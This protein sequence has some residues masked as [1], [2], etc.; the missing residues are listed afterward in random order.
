MMSAH[1]HAEFFHAVAEGEA[2]D[3]EAYHRTLGWRP[4]TLHL[5]DIYLDPTRWE[6]R[7]KLKTSWQRFNEAFPPEEYETEVRLRMWEAW[8][9]AEWQAEEKSDV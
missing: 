6:V 2:V 9:Q 1:R 4:A 5:E 3:W 8:I 7:R